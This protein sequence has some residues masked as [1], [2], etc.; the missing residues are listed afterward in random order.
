ILMPAGVLDRRLSTNSPQVAPLLLQDFPEVEQAARLMPRSARIR[1][2]DA[3]YAE[4]YIDFAD[5]SLFS[6]FDF[7]WLQG[8]PRS[9]LIQPDSVVLTE[10]SARKYFNSVDVLGQTIELE[11]RRLLTV[12]GVIADLPNHTHMVASMF[13]SM[14]VVTSFD[15]ENALTNWSNGNFNT[16]VL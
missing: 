14:N 2:G 9:A 10:S 8:D 12:T 13:V 11:E 4:D 6:I 16:Y 15:G 5:A 1:V 7:E 3:I